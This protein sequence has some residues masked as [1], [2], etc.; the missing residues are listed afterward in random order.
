[1][2]FFHGDTVGT[3]ALLELPDHLLLDLSDD[4]LVHDGNLTLNDV[5]AFI[6]TAPGKGHAVEIKSGS[7]ITSDFFDGLD[8]WRQNLSDL[9]IQP[10]LVYGGETRQDRDRATVLPW[11]ALDSLLDAVAGGAELGSG[12]Q[13]VSE[14]HQG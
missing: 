2:F 6:E 4:Q 13:G 8:F 10:W 14:P 11:R 5:D 7:T 1:V 3:G 12:N 9:Q